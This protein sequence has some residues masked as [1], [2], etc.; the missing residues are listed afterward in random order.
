MKL[1]SLLFTSLLGGMAL[2]T[3]VS[4][5]E[6]TGNPL[7]DPNDVTIVNNEPVNTMSDYVFLELSA[8]QRNMVESSNS[9]AFD[10][11]KTTIKAEEVSDANFTMSP[12]SWFAALS[13]LANGDRGPVGSEIL[14]VL[15]GDGESLDL[16]GLNELNAYLLEKLPAVDPVTMLNVANSLWIQE[17]MTPQNEFL[18]A[19]TESYKSEFFSRKLS[20]SDTRKAINDWCLDKTNGL[21]KDFLKKNLSEKAL[22]VILNATYFKGIWRNKFL[23]SDTSHSMFHGSAG[24]QKVDMMHTLN[25]FLYAD[26]DTEEAIMLPYGSGNYDMTVVMPKEGVDFNDYVLSMSSEGFKSLTSELTSCEVDFSLPK[27]TTGSE[28]TI[29]KALKAMGIVGAYEN[30]LCDFL[31]EKT[32]CINDAISAVRIVVDEEGT[33][34]GAV[35]GMGMIEGAS[36]PHELRKV[37]MTVDR[38]FLFV[39]TESSTNTVLFIGKVSKI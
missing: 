36:S 14:E 30:E 16:D 4:C 18:N 37:K 27:F 19:M 32:V 2:M 26:D 35:S 12:Y 39:I 13:M 22:A 3:T 31:N 8:P 10:L 21:I 15:S 9:F 33:E 23:K 7:T 17:G 11:F 24:D 1:N 38:P 5:S 6:T 34:A 28:L 25:T 29:N 20:T